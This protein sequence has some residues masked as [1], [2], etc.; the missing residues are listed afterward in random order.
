VFVPQPPIL[1]MVLQKYFC[2]VSSKGKKT[3]KTKIKQNCTKQKNPTKCPKFKCN[4]FSKF[5]SMQV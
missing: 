5:F 2:G 3:G 1:E 4:S